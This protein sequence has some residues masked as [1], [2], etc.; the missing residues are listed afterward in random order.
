MKTL[1]AALALTLWASTAVAQNF[2]PPQLQIGNFL[3][4][5]MTDNP[6]TEMHQISKDLS[7]FVQRFNA[8]PPPSEV[9]VDTVY[10]FTKPNHTPVYMILVVGDC[11][12]AHSAIDLDKFLHL[13]DGVPLKPTKH[14]SFEDL[15]QRGLREASAS[16]S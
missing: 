14:E 2:C 4:R 6:D 10:Y 5:F 15:L 11:V 9:P 1:I 12:V 8:Y 13:K 3:Q 7:G 16:H